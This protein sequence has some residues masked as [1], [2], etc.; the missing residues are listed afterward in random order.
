MLLVLGILVTKYRKD[1]FRNQSVILKN[2]VVTLSRH[3]FTYQ[4]M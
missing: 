1:L 3:F 4:V 2:V